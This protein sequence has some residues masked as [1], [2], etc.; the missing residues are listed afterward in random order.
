MTTLAHVL[1]YALALTAIDMRIR[2]VTQMLP[3][4]HGL[5]SAVLGGVAIGLVTL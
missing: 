5:G 1:G 4:Y 2:Y 3:W